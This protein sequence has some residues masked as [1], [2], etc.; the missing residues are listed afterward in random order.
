M[1][2]DK[3][4]PKG[5]VAVN[6][7]GNHWRLR[8]PRTL[9]GGKQEFIALGLRA[10]EENLKEAEALALK[11]QRDIDAGK[12]DH[13]YQSYKP[14]RLQAINDGNNCNFDK[15]SLLDLFDKYI[16]AKEKQ[17]KIKTLEEYKTQRNYISRF[18]FKLISHHDLITRHIKNKL[19]SH[20]ARKLLININACCKWALKERLIN[21][22]SFEGAASE[23]KVTKNPEDDIDPFTKEERDAVIEAY[24]NHEV[25]QRYAPYV[26]FLFFSGCRPSE[27]IYLKWKHINF[28][29]KEILIEGASVRVRGKTYEQDSTKTRKNRKFKINDRLI[30]ILKLVQPID[31]KLEDTVFTES[32]KKPINPD[33]FYRSWRGLDNGQK[34]Y[35][36]IIPTLV[37]QGKLS[38]YHNPYQTRHTFATLAIKTGTPVVD[39]AKILGNSSQVC[40]KHYIFATRDLRVPDLD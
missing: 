35:I 29:K 4:S 34:K 15:V 8:L 32:N 24:K 19:P 12:F 33:N 9:F 5:T 13:T 40:Y 7:N 6:K 1:S 14:N 27:V 23:I 21:N 16:E 3:R 38:K 18:P 22:N 10:T 30:K 36:G 28:D 20:T 37:K 17:V 11:A 26:E 31:F 39:L 25:Y 2:S